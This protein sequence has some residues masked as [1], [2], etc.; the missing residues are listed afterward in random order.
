MKRLILFLLLFHSFLFSQNT[1]NGTIID[2]KTSE[3]LIGANIILTN[4]SEPNQTIGA[5]T[6]FDGKFKFIPPDAGA[7][8]FTKYDWHI[9][10]SV[11]DRYF[12]TQ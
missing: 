6:N 4:T 12:L 2:Q 7:M 10:S 3:T 11:L 9:N 1:I 8:A 5:A